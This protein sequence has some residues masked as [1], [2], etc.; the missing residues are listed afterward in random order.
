M[1][2][3]IA[4][5]IV[6][7]AAAAVGAY[8]FRSPAAAAPEKPVRAAT[9]TDVAPILAQHCVSCHT[10]GGVAP[11]P[12]TNAA[13]AHR[14]AQSIL[15][16]VQLGVMPPWPPGRDSPAFVGESRRVLTPAEKATI[17]S[18]VAAG[19]PIGAGGPT[20]PPPATAPSS[21]G[22]DV[23]LAP[24][25][26]Y[27]PHTTSGSTDDYH[28]F[29]LDPHL[30]QDAFVTS[31]VVRPQR[32]S[33]V[34][35]VI[36]FE[37]T[38]SGVAQ[39][40]QLNAAG[41]GKGWTCF[42]GPEVTDGASGAAVGDRLG[43]PQ[44]IA[45]WVPGHVT[46]DLPSG[47][48]V[49]LHAGSV[50]VMQEHYNLLHGSRSDRSS[51]GLRLV[52]AAG[53][54]LIPLDTLLYPAPVELPCPNGVR[55]SLCNRATALAVEQRKYGAE[56]AFIPS[57]LL[58]ICR[59]T[60]AD[61]PQRVGN[62]SRITTSCDR[63]V[64]RPIRI[65]GVAGHM[66]LRGVD[67]ELTLNPGTPQAQVLLH[68]PRWNFHWQDMY[69]LEHPIDAN[70]GDTIRVSCRYDNSKANQPFIGSK[71]LAPRYVLWGEGTTDEMCLGAV[72]AATRTP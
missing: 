3:R 26:A 27:K 23:T 21:A 41:G 47:T 24:P 71:Q 31:A 72:Q 39:A 30:A 4:A 40:Q 13:D 11:F 69:Y 68:I 16:A 62:G 56:A 66:H 25:Q 29:L 65:Y 45:A 14:Y 64:T 37:V 44:W 54:N 12:L 61:Y 49:L 43:S 67:I 18:W 51:V 57:A 19:A 48:G 35:H 70:P 7:L 1:R 46:N 38:G 58:A 9:W 59:K 8:T 20:G 6:V 32:R 2:S 60:L 50:I 34:H 53:A 28:C 42:G 17:R 10:V 52:D 63:R 36:L 5:V 33:E 15:A 55:S 22:R